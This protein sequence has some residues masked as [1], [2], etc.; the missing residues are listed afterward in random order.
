MHNVSRLAGIFACAATLAAAGCAGGSGVTPATGSPTAATVMSQIDGNS[1]TLIYM[2]TLRNAQ[3]VH[4]QYSNAVYGGGPL[5][6][7]PKMY[8][9]FWGFK[10]AGDPDKVAPLLE[11]FQS[12]IG[13]STHNEIYV[14]YKGTKKFITNPK[15]QNGNFWMDDKNAIPTSPTDPQVAAESLEG[16]KHFGYDPNGSYVVVSATGH[17]TPGFE[18]SWCAYH[19]AVSDPKGQ[20]VSYTNLPY[21]PDAGSNCGASIITA[22]N[23]ETGIDEGVTIVEGHE[24]GESVTDPQPTSGYYNDSWGEIGDICAWQDIENDP[25][26]KYS[27]TSQPMWSNATSTCVQDYKKKK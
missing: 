9:I 23:D 2:P 1:H 14:Q 6:Y 10:K 17:H 21:Q 16:V 25:F 19:S 15:N 22:P 26:G 12:S 7:K 11:Q 13:G 8:L 3:K 5:L 20:V 24:Y 18:T 27:W 4:P